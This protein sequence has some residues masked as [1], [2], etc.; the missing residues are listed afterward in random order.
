MLNRT[1]NNSLAILSLPLSLMCMS[2]VQLEWHSIRVSKAKVE[3]CKMARR[4]KM[5]FPI[6]AVGICPIGQDR[7]PGR[8]QSKKAEDVELKMV[9]EARTFI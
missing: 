8:G 9:A 6:V 2:M 7:L 5:H 3:R 4:T 1:L